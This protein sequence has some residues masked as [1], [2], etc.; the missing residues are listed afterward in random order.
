MDAFES[1]PYGRILPNLRV[2]RCSPDLRHYADFYRS[3][4]VLYGPNIQDFSTWCP[5][6]SSTVLKVDEGHWKETV[7]RLHALAPNLCTLNM[8]ADNQPFVP[9]ISSLVSSVVAATSKRLRA[10]QIGHIPINLNALRH[11]AALPSLVVFSAKL[12]DN[13]T[14][15]DLVLLL[16][17][18][19]TC[20]ATLQELHLAHSRDL[21]LLTL[22]VHL[23]R[24]TISR[25]QMLSLDILNAQVPFNLV[26]HFLED[27]LGHRDV[28]YPTV[29]SLECSVDPESPGPH[30]L[31]EDHLRPFFERKHLKWFQLGV[32]CDFDVDNTTLKKIAA[33]W[34]NI[35]VFTLGPSPTAK[36]S[37][38]TL[39]GLIPLARQCPHL[40][41]LGLTVDP[42]LPMEAPVDLTG[43]YGSLLLHGPT[44]NV[45]YALSPCRD[46]C[47]SFR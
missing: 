9:A 8:N 1:R 45:E 2:L 4:S 35:V 26:T 28:D 46:T 12:D 27:I 10:I 42:T 23:T 30:V 13:I 41:V 34:P 25:L 32:T 15:N 24:P 6:V 38:V 39:E 17:P 44:V 37:K 22:F 36:T 20:F 29:I 19:R 18:G 7:T 43:P 40:K 21:F 14:A 11:L 3:F 16:K 33:A 47:P 31:T 5:Y